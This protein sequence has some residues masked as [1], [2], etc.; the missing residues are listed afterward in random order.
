MALHGDSLS[1]A[2]GPIEEGRSGRLG[3]RSSR[4]TEAADQPATE[5]PEQHLDKYESLPPPPPGSVPVAA[6]LHIRVE[7]NPDVPLTACEVRVNGGPPTA[8]NLLY[9][10]ETVVGLPLGSHALEFEAHIPSRGFGSGG[11][12]CVSKQVVV[13]RAD[14]SRGLKGLLEGFRRASWLEVDPGGDLWLTCSLQLDTTVGERGRSW[15]P[16]ANLLV[17]VVPPPQVTGLPVD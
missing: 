8:L 15:H 10:A 14:R 6:R 7:S 1:D 5:P 13:G 4:H 3:P 16:P 9:P 11:G 17:T 12:L 2:S